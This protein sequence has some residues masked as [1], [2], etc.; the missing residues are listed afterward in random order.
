MA[1]NQLL[2]ALSRRGLNPIIRLVYTRMVGAFSF[3]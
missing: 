2:D 3:N 1:A